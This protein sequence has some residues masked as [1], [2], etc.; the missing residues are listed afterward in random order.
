ML[1]YF[2]LPQ[3]IVFGGAFWVWSGA[4]SEYMRKP[5]SE[6]RNSDVVSWME[7]LGHW[8][9]PN[10]TRIFINEVCKVALIGL[11]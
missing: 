4:D 1:Y 11:G 3:V 6:W 5:V 9:K 2:P 10:I 7:A 8:T